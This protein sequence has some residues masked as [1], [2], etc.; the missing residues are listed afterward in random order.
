MFLCVLKM[1][2]LVC[3]KGGAI[4][5]LPQ[6]HHQLPPVCPRRLEVLLRKWSKFQMI[7]VEIHE[8]VKWHLPGS[9]TGQAPIVNCLPL[10]M[11]T[12]DINVVSKIF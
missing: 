12:G 11:P 8:I 1:C 3:Q 6:G 4:P 5:R 2:F 9:P 10:S 7:K